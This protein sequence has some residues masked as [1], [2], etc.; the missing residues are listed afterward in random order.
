MSNSQLP[1]N[2]TRSNSVSSFTSDQLEEDED[3]CD[4][5][6]F[7]TA[8]FDITGYHEGTGTIIIAKEGAK[9][10]LTTNYYKSADG[11]LAIKFH[12]TDLLEV[13]IVCEK[14]LK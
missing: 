10:P 6:Q 12:I 4:T 7:D 14:E 1:T 5:V 3:S 11:K 8:P 9:L 13:S 2:L